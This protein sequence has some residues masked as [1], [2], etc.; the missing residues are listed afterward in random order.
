MGNTGTHFF[1]NPV[2]VVYEFWKLRNTCFFADNLL[3]I[4][5]ADLTGNNLYKRHKRTLRTGFNNITA[6]SDKKDGWEFSPESYGKDRSSCHGF[7]STEPG[8]LLCWRIR[9]V[10]L[11]EGHC[12]W[13]ESI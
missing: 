9:A 4:D 3:N 13:Y 7:P 11:M 5:V 12:T 8:I 2:D 6:P 1:N 10:M